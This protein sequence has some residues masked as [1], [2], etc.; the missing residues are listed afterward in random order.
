MSYNYGIHYRATRLHCNVD[1]LSRL[2]VSSD[3]EFD[4]SEEACLNITSTDDQLVKSFPMN[5]EVIAKVTSEDAILLRVRKLIENGWPEK[6]NDDELK[7]YFGRSCAFSIEKGIIVYHTAG[8][9]RVTIPSSLQSRILEML[10][11]G[12]WRIIPMKLLSRR[13]CWWPNID[14]DIENVVKH[15]QSCQMVQPYPSKQFRR[16]PKTESPWE[17][18][19]VDFAGLFMNSMWMIVFDAYSKYSYVSQVKNLTAETT[20]E[21]LEK[22]FLLEVFLD[23]SFRSFSLVSDNGTQFTSGVFQHFCKRNGISVCKH[24]HQ[25]SSN[26][27]SSIVK[28][29]LLRKTE[30]NKML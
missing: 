28:L 22:I 6:L 4:K 10:H 13:Y 29:G 30:Q 20:I 26:F 25:I 15:C 3:N 17:R 14:K 1:A 5:S 21:A 24:Q 19:H 16:W 2:P 18:I 8:Y 12:H 27:E 23:F 11:E 9:S 7:S